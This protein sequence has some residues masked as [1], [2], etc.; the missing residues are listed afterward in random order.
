LDSGKSQLKTSKEL[1][2]SESSIRYHLRKGT[3]KNLLKSDY[4]PQGGGFI[5]DFCFASQI[6]FNHTSLSGIA[7]QEHDHTPNGF[8]RLFKKIKVFNTKG[9][10]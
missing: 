8:I 10:S 4:P 2:I 3:V 5:P 9:A 1:S 7:P 6:F